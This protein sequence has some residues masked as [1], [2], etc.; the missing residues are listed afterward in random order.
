MRNLT[1]TRRKSYV[2]CAMKD[3]VY[4]DPMEVLK[5]SG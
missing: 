2:G 4:I 3:Q 1:I 5:I